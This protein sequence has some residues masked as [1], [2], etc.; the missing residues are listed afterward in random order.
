M[1]DKAEEKTNKK[2]K[3]FK[4]SIQTKRIKENEK[5]HKKYFC[6]K[7]KFL[8]GLIQMIQ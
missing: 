6:C 7:K 4:S 5:K 2:M 3:E 8:V 1:A